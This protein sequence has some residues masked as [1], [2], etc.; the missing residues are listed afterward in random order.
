MVLDSESGTQ[1]GFAPVGGRR[2]RRRGSKRK[3]RRGS[4]KSTRKGMR[5]RTARRAYMKR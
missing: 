3:T 4:R 1:L 2:R 5:R